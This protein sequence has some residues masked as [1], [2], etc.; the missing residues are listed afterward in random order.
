MSTETA[1]KK[2]RSVGTRPK[3]NLFG[4]GIGFGLAGLAGTWTA[5]AH[6][7]L[8]PTAVSTA[9]WLVA[10]CAWLVLVLRF[11]HRATLS[12]LGE[13]LR[14]PVL[15]PFAALLP[16]TG[17]LL[18]GQLASTDRVIG[19]AFVVSMGLL[20]ATFGTWFFSHLL[21]GSM[22]VDSLHSGYLLP[23]TAATLIGG[24]SLA[25][26]GWPDAGRTAFAVGLLSW[27]MLGPLLLG[28][29]AFRPPLPSALQP[30]F[31]IFSAPPAVAGNAWFALN[32]PSVDAFQQAMLGCFALLVGVQLFKVRS[33]ARLPFALSWWALTFT[34]AASATFVV[35]VSAASAYSY[36]RAVAWAAVVAASLVIGFIAIQSIRLVVRSRHVAASRVQETTASCWAS[37]STR[38]SSPTSGGSGPRH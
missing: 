6:A 27:L 9:L 15:G 18:G 7:G 24:Q 20:A 4:I 26:A 1:D 10:A 36:W 33:Y 35:Q 2:A 14:D 13:E 8:A 37:T 25:L 32:G 23:T 28:R 21:G 19:L 34:T 3:L 12:V 31:A 29:F 5:A 22:D 17:L 30:S 16:T 11:L 38:V